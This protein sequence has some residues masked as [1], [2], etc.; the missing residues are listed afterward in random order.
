M[1]RLLFVLY[2]VIEVVAFWSVAA[3]IGFGWAFLLVLLGSALGVIAFGAQARRLFE[4]LSGRPGTRGSG[5]G[6]PRDSARGVGNAL[7]DGSLS[8][9]G[10]AFLLV[11]GLVTSILGLLLLFPPTR[12]VLR[13]LV[14]R[15]GLRRV[16]MASSVAGARRARNRS[17]V[18]DGDVVDSSGADS[19]AAGS[20][21][22]RSPAAGSSVA[23]PTVIDGDVVDGHGAGG[24]NGALFPPV[25][26]PASRPRSQN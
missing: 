13:P 9:T 21:A 14:V 3:A 17:R 11:P 25:I 23:D 2:V 16:P 5:R 19:P 15:L 20:P 4:S 12:K 8:M 6:S 10:V 7:A 1:I 24:R 18:V 26:P 22:A